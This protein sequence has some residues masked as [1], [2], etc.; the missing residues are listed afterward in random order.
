MSGAGRLHGILARRWM[1]VPPV[2]LAANFLFAASAVQLA[3]R[4]HGTAAEPDYY[5]KALA[6]DEAHAARTAGERLRWTVSPSLVIEEGGRLRLELAIADKYGIPIDGALVRV[7]AIPVRAA[8]LAASA[9][10]IERAPGAYEA[11]FPIGASGQYEFRIS[12]ER[13][14]DRL[15]ERFRRSVERRA[16]VARVRP[17]ESAPRAA[18]ACAAASRG[19]VP[20]GVS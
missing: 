3:L 8:D 16:V 15:E 9:R 5:R 10:A 12:I 4:D 13:G 18:E 19:T 7:E 11:R 20:G 14:S 2:L 1:L 17:E 6:W